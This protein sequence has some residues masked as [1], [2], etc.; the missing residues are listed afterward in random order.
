MHRIR[1]SST[2]RNRT[3]TGETNSRFSINPT[4]ISSKKWLNMK[5]VRVDS[6]HIPN[7][8]INIP[9][10]SALE[11][12][13]NG[14][15]TTKVI[16]QK[17]QY[18][19]DEL[20]DAMNDANTTFKLS[21]DTYGY[22]QCEQLGT[23][24]IQIQP[25]NRYTNY[26]GYLL[27]FDQDNV[28]DTTSIPTTISAPYYSRMSVDNH[29]CIIQSKAFGRPTYDATAP[30][31]AEVFQLAVVP[32]DVA[33]GV[34]AH[35]FPNNEVGTL[36]WQN[37]PKPIPGVWD[38]TLRNWRGERMDIGDQDWSMVLTVFYQ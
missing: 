12:L 13:L 33:F 32:M 2:D 20:I 38:F 27:G 4:N 28:S 5:G 21:I 15:A 23:D 29:C 37:A 31:S 1:I 30:G 3:K 22:V 18:T 11:F 25:A 7:T 35:H 8:F 9:Q 10:D 34:T 17:G 14:V 16:G 24:T 6:V 19:I 36:L 26:I